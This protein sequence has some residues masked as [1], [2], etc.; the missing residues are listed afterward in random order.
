[1][2]ADVFID[3]NILLYAISKRPEEITKTHKAIQ[4]L[5]TTDFGLSAQVL[6]E[7]YVVSTGKMAQRIDTKMAVKFL[8]ILSK[9]PVVSTDTDLVLAAIK[10]QKMYQISYWDAA[11]L[12][13]AEELEARM[14]YS[15]DLNHMQTYGTTQIINPFLGGS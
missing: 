9:Y 12:A 14:V 13:A 8:N 3:T 6:Q 4:I 15:E 5:R 1:M 11:I 2:R 7:F 10:L